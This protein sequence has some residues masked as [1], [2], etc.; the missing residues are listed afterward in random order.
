LKIRIE[1]LGAN[2]ALT[3]LNYRHALRRVRK[4][5]PMRLRLRLSPMMIYP[6]LDRFIPPA[7]AADRELQ[8]GA[9]MFLISHLLGPFLGHT[10]TVY[11]YWIDPH[12]GF[13][14][15][16]LVASIS[17]FWA[18]PYALKRTGAYTPLA[19]AS[20]QN[21]IF[22]VLWGSYHYGGVSSP[23]VAWLVTVPLLAFMYLGPAS[24]PRLAVLG[25]IALNVGV[26]YVFYAAG[27]DF[28][29]HIPLR[30]LSGI[31]IVS[32]SSA[33]VYV[34]MMALYYSAIV[35]NQ[36]ELQREAQSHRATAI[37]LREAKEEAENANRA[38]SEFL[39]KMSHELR[40]PLN[41]VIGYSEMLLEDAEVD[42]SEEQAAQDL[43]KINSAGKHLLSLV[44]DVLDLSKIEAGKM[45]LYN[46]RF[47][48]G[49]LIDELIETATPLCAR[50]GNDLVVERAGPLGEVECDVT[51][52][53]QAA[54]NLLSNAAK[55]TRGGSVVLTVAREP[56]RGGDWIR[57][58]VR[59]TGIGISRDNLRKLFQKFSQAEAWTS[60]KYGGTGL[61]LALTQ[62]L[63]HLMGGDVAVESELDQGSNFTIRLPASLADAVQRR[64]EV[65]WPAEPS[66]AEASGRRDVI[67]VVDDDPAVL[68]LMQRILTK[69]GFHPVL[70]DDP[71]KALSLAK[72]MRPSVIVLDV[73]M[74]GMNGWEVLRA[75]KGDPELDS[76]PVV[77][78]TIVDDRRTGLALGAAEHLVKPVDR[79]VLMRVLD[80]VC[81]RGK[82]DL[83]APTNSKPMAANA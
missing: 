71:H 40:T 48:L 35:A 7:I 75:I 26:F 69:E 61:G 60:T 72:A 54:L 80:R 74:P 81:P 27:H 45:E 78:L 41:A 67:L 8:L 73:L 44:T 83:S 20:V 58:S 15:W 59:D 17:A 63:C 32:M 13:G 37:K 1:R 56:A 22:A 79:D 4:E 12:P 23:F 50:N 62:K 24:G 57:I 65:D 19:L 77:M 18:F 82:N 70:A 53:R 51:K 68:D 55:F 28:P 3:F 5:P 21:L 2:Y 34:S 25:M 16:V 31:G 66:S 43:K 47:E 11:L 36:S 33:A 39:A 76:V 42:P 38:K 6:L 30:S 49:G 9:R 14:L 52:L 46:E 64:S 10:I 29:E